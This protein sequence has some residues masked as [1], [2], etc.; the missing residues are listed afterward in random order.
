MVRLMKILKTFLSLIL[1][2][3]VNTLVNADTGNL[4][5]RSNRPPNIVLILADD[6]GYGELGCYGQKVDRN[7]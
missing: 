7:P 4:P 5:G 2:V 1:L 6:L 3:L